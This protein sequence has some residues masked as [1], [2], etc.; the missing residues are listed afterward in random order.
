MD[1]GFISDLHLGHK[2]IAAIRGYEDVDEYNETVIKRWNSV[3]GKRTIIYNLGDVTMEN[4][5]AYH[6]LSRLKGRHIL[7]GGNHDLRKDQTEL[8]KYVESISGAMKYKGFI[9]THIPIHSQ[10]VSRFIGNIHGH[11]HTETVKRLEYTPMAVKVSE[12]MDF[13]YL[14]VS[15]DQLNGYPI[16]FEEILKKFNR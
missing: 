13:R 10:E 3:T 7:I 4:D 16:S 15:W 11:M 14:N 2:A 1:I 6:L 9:C 8:L 12:T 5:K